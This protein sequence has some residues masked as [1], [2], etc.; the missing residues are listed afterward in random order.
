M[1]RFFIWL[2]LILISISYYKKYRCNWY[3][4]TKLVDEKYNLVLIEFLYYDKKLN[5]K[6]GKILVPKDSSSEMKELLEE[7]FLE[8]ISF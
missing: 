5:I 6:K 3:F 1:I 4:Q 2:S 7:H 8:K